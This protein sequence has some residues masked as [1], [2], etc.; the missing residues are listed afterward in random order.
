M[1]MEHEYIFATVLQKKLKPVIKGK[2]Y[3]AIIPGDELVVKIQ[4]DDE[5]PFRLFIPNVT[6]KILYGW[7]TDDAVRAVVS[8]YKK[9]LFEKIQERYF[10]ND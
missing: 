1:M 7:S 3:V 5:E 4:L 6:Q 8:N 2:I 9:Y 10:Y